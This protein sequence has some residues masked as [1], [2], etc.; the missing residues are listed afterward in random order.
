MTLHTVELLPTVDRDL[1]RLARERRVKPDEL[2]AD[3][4]GRYLREHGELALRIADAKRAI[5]ATSRGTNG[6]EN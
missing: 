5:A 3:A 6:Q 2:I 4:V 1:R